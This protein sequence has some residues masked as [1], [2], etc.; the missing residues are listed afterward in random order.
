M[1]HAIRIKMSKDQGVQRMII[2]WASRKNE[3][4]Y[5]EVHVHRSHTQIKAPR[6]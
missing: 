1:I 3:L 5:T 4:V 2:E 6:L